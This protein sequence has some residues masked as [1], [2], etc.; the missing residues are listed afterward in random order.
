MLEKLNI[1]VV[2]VLNFCSQ[3]HHLKGETAQIPRKYSQH[4]Y[5]TK[6][7]YP[8]YIKTETNN[9]IKNGPKKLAKLLAKEL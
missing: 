1:H 7:L 3:R 5:L 9:P 4:T 2:K 6:D 8:K